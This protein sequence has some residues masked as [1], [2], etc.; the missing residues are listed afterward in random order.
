MMFS[1]IPSTIFLASDSTLYSGFFLI[2]PCRVLTRK[3]EVSQILLLKCQP[4]GLCEALSRHPSALT[5]VAT[6]AEL[7]P[8]Y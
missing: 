7:Q 8:R 3:D 1:S 5:G 2:V 4:S 6:K